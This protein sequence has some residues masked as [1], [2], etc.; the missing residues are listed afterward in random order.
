MCSV[1]VEC[2]GSV[3]DYG[4]YQCWE[5]SERGEAMFK[6]AGICC[7]TFCKCQEVNT[8]KYLRRAAHSI[9]HT[10]Y[11]S[12]SLNWHVFSLTANTD[13][14]KGLALQR[15]VDSKNYNCITAF[16]TIIRNK[17]LPI[18]LSSSMCWPDYLF[19]SPN[20]LGYSEWFWICYIN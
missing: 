19:L 1:W 18:Q 15:A 2:Q 12:F 20:S 13:F 9:N 4:S 16:G 8:M 10:V 11:M 14:Y 7:S 3:G 17:Q 5:Q 6:N